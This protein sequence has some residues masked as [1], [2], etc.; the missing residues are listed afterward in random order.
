MQYWDDVLYPSFRATIRG[1]YYGII[2]IDD[3][4]EECFNI[5]RRAIAAFKFPKISTAYT[6]FYAVRDKED[7]NLLVEADEDSEG[8]IPHGYF[9]TDIGDSE[10]QIILA[11]MKYFW[12]EQKISNA[13]NF[14]D[15]YT[16]ANI[17]TYSRANVVAQNLKLMEH[18]RENARELEMSYGRVN[19]VQQPAMGDINTDEIE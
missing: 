12:C 7:K 5:A 14:E 11:W 6:V 9:N 2:S 17:K 10:V 3:M 13:D 16:D 19:T 18:Y 8:A 1:E 4:D 15:M